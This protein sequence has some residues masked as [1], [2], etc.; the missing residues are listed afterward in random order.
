MVRIV[1]S[2]KRTTTYSHSWLSDDVYMVVD[3]VSLGGVST[4]NEQNP[5]SHMFMNSCFQ[6]LYH[7]LCGTQLTVTQKPPLASLMNEFYTAY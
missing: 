1:P 5:F 7:I 2:L 3:Q 6:M 4:R